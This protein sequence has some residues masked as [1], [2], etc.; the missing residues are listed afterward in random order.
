[1]LRYNAISNVYFCSDCH[2]CRRRDVGSVWTESNRGIL[3]C[4]SNW[5]EYLFYLGKVAPWGGVLEPHSGSL[6]DLLEEKVIFV[7][8]NRLG[9]IVLIDCSYKYFINILVF[10]LIP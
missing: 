1:M 9:S 10:L 6:E 2:P 7:K 4:H 8:G 3:S 5:L